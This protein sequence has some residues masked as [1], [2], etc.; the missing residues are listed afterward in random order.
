MMLTEE[1]RLVQEQG[2]TWASLFNYNSLPNRLPVL[3]WLVLLALVGLAVLP[4]TLF[5][6]QWLP[7]RG[8]IL[9]RVV[10]V[11][12]LAW[13][14]WTLTNLT[15]LHYSR[16]TILL[17][18]GLLV[19]LSWGSL[20][21]TGQRRRLGDLWRT[22]KRSILVGEVLFLVFFGVFLLIRMGNPDL[23][24]AYKGGEKPMDFAYLN[25]VIKSTEFPPYDPW[26]AGGY[27]NYYYFGQVIVGTLIK[28]IGLVPAVAYNLVIPSWFAMTAMGAF[29]LTF[30]LVASSGK[31]KAEEADAAEG[32][33]ELGLG[34]PGG[35]PGSSSAGEA[36]STEAPV[37]GADLEPGGPRGVKPYLFGLVGALFVAVLGNLGQA[38]LILG[39]LGE[40]MAGNFDSTIPGLTGLVRVA[41]GFFEVIFS[42]RTM[43]IAIDE[44]YW[45]ASRAIPQGPGE[46]VITEFP[47]FTFLYGD[48][49]AHLIA[50]PLALLSLAFALALVKGAAGHQ[51]PGLGLSRVPAVGPGPVVTDPGRHPHD[52]LLGRAGAPAAGSG[53]A[54]HRRVYAARAGDLAPGVVRGLAVGAGVRP[55][56][57]A[58]LLALLGQL[59]LLL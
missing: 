8:Y 28:L 51:A 30:N 10:G 1:Q 15:P 4:V 39:K 25:A 35:G 48:L 11:L 17:A 55:E 22:Q 41:V 6:F 49:H 5:A 58:A 21:L 13:L 20:L 29:S 14:T 47:F 52:Q 46:A 32:S 12:L 24:H 37:G 56:L 31:V 38:V 40:G 57:V 36:G 3:S 19:L 23:W 33:A 43:P 54:G 27:L 45:N 34:D 53:G 44:W 18:L 59:W 2:G 42:G 9:S 7:D 26:F 16:G 50:L